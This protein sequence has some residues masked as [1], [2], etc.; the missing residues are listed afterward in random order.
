[1]SYV[2][3]CVCGCNGETQVKLCVHYDDKL[4][5]NYRSKDYVT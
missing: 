1:M 4:I 3:I 2:G 5:N